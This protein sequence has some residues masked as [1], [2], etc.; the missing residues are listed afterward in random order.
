M[1]GALLLMVAGVASLFLHGQ[2]ARDGLTGRGP[3]P[4]IEIAS[5]QTEA[6]ARDPAAGAPAK[7]AAPPGI[8]PLE[9]ARSEAPLTRVPAPSK[10]ASGEADPYSISGVVMD[11][12]GRGVFGVPVTATAKT[13]FVDERAGAPDRDP[14][15]TALTDVDGFYA[16]EGVADGEYRL[17]AEPDDRYEAAE[18]VVRAGAEGADLILR[19]R[20]PGLIVAGTVRSDGEPLEG[21]EV[22]VVAAGQPSEAVLTDDDGFY[23]TMLRIAAG[24]PS[25][26]VSFTRD[27]YREQRSVLMADD[28]AGP[29]PIRVDADLEP[30]QAI[31]EVTGSVRDREGQPV[32]GEMVQLYSEAARQRY[33]AVSGRR[34]EIRFPEVET[35]DDYMVSVRP[36]D[37]YRDF[38]ASDVQVGAAGANLDIVLEP[39]SYGRLVGQM[40][41]P[42]GLPVPSFSLWLRN[43]EAVN[44]PPRLVTGDQQGFFDIDRVEAGSLVFETRGSPLVS[45]SGIE[46]AAGETR[47]VL[48]VLDWGTHQVAGLVMD[49][50]GRPVSASELYVTSVRDDRGLRA[51]VVRRAVTDETGFFVV[52]QVGSGYHTIRVDSPGFRSAVIDHE[53]GRDGPEVIIRLERARSHGM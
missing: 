44:Q 50:M 27:G 46:L 5:G 34:G 18:A 6:V 38:L 40:V 12:S 31:V 41:N 37:A 47:D 11:E 35:S 19:E 43:P 4:A 24:K 10:S 52:G 30:A 32:A 13:L 23:E 51:H 7:P 14:P 21:V 39:R 8:T 53:V 20:R 25:Y 36:A 9:Q 48:L 22:V 17:R 2:G 33:T 16:I 28:L 1:A 3:A 15:S 26:T 42:D 29:G 49:D 45:I